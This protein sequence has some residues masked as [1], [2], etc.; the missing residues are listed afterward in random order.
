MNFL[1]STSE[2]VIPSL[3]SWWQQHDCVQCKTQIQSCTSW[4]QNNFLIST[5]RKVTPPQCTIQ[6]SSRGEMPPDLSVSA[7]RKAVAKDLKLSRNFCFTSL[8][9]WCAVIFFSIG[10]RALV[11]YNKRCASS[12]AVL[13]A[14]KTLL[15]RPKRTVGPRRLISSSLSMASNTD[16]R[17]QRSTTLT[18]LSWIFFAVATARF[19]FLIPNPA[20]R[21]YEIL[22]TLQ[23]EKSLF[24]FLLI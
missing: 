23:H 10:F 7:W 17:Q 14:A 24:L 3:V 6:R 22:H 19:G 13:S 4:S 11:P 2:T 15:R 9:A 20:V 8:A 12:V 16:R 1:N 5:S 21:F 18:K